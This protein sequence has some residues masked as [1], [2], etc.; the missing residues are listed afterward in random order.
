VRLT[1]FRIR[2]K[3]FNG[4][5][6]FVQFV[7]AASLRVRVGERRMAMDREVEVVIL[8]RTVKLFLANASGVCTIIC[9]LRA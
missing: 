3:S 5:L 9:L 6:S 2:L 1:V 8:R 7:A 4:H